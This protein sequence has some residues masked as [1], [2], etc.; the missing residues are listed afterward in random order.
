MG[1]SIIV[2]PA[3][4]IYQW[5]KHFHEWSPEFRC[6][7]L[8]QSGSFQ[9]NKI[10]LIKDI[11]KNKG[12]IITTYLAILKFKGNLLEYNWHYIILDEGHKIRNPTTK[13]C[14]ALKLF[15]TPHRI[16]LTGSPMQNNLTELWSLFDFTNPGMLG[17]LNTFQEHF[18][19][20]ILRGGFANSTPMQEATALSVAQAL[21]NV[22]A[23]YL[24]RRTKTEVQ[25]HICLPNKSEQVL[26]CSLT[27]EQKDLYK[28][29]LLVRID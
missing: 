19:T 20:P 7:V 1:P 13:I 25:H 12:I 24:L 18:I 26:F 23:P 28:G 21:K 9:G 22:I 8:H 29:F 6:C 17:N 15:R 3:T 27:S 5:V 14:I 11:N 10:N 16:M 2:C 4:V